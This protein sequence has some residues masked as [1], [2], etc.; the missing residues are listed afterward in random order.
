MLAAAR[1][2][3]GCEE[4]V[5]SPAKVSVLQGCQGPSLLWKAVWKTQVDFAHGGFG[6]GWSEI[7]AQTDRRLEISCT[8]AS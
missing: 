1:G 4:V 7:V 8:V 3:R 5:V 6:G 2:A